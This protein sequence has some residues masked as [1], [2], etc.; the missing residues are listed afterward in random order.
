MRRAIPLLL[1][2]LLVVAPVVALAQ[3]T[4]SDGQQAPITQDAGTDQNQNN[5]GSPVDP[6]GDTV[7]PV[8]PGEFAGKLTALIVGIRD[9]VGGI[10]EPLSGLSLVVCAAILIAAVFL[11]WHTAKRLALGGIILVVFGLMVYWFGPLVLG[12]IKSIARSL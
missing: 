12:V 6:W 1:L 3:E 8:P 4:S 10:L 7:K 2:M 11:G 9:T 5:T